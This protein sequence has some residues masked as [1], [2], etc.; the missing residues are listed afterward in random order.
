MVLAPGVKNCSFERAACWGI[1]S[2]SAW[3][4][5]PGEEGKIR[6]FG[7]KNCF[8]VLARCGAWRGVS[9]EFMRMMTGE[10]SEFILVPRNDLH[11][12][13]PRDISGLNFEEWLVVY[14]GGT[15]AYSLWG[16]IGA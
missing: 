4:R 1:Q 7:T 8:P 6:W 16:N 10:V 15:R 2:L 12:R 5:F 9:P 13:Q 14:D 3:C 11:D